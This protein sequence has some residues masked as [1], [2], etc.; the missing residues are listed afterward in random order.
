M[1]SFDELVAM[2]HEDLV[3]YYMVESAAIVEAASID[4]KD[5][6]VKLRLQQ[7]MRMN[8]KGSY[9]LAQDAST[10]MWASFQELAVA[11]KVLSEHT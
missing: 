6:L 2:S 9:K 4:L 11:W 3:E 10:E 5:D 8:R 7:I 1:K